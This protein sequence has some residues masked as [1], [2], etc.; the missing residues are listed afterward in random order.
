MKEKKKTYPY[1]LDWSL[2]LK[3]SKSSK[4]F[5]KKYSKQDI[6]NKYFEKKFWGYRCKFEPDF[7]I[8]KGVLYKDCYHCN[9]SWI[10]VEPW[11]QFHYYLKTYL[12]KQKQKTK[13]F[14]DLNWNIR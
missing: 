4:K 8:K 1:E 11:E 5:T 12:E 7:Y 6:I 13:I 2:G 10:N 14:E 9:R 3:S